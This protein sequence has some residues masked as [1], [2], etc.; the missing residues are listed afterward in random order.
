M[1]WADCRDGALGRL[2][3]ACFAWRCEGHYRK[4]KTG[5]PHRPGQT[6]QHAPLL[7][8]SSHSDRDRD[9]IAPWV[10][11]EGP[12]AMLSRS[13]ALAVA[14]QMGRAL[15]ESRDGRA[16]GGSFALALSRSRHCSA[17]GLCAVRVEC[18]KAV[19][20]LGGYDRGYWLLIWLAGFPDNIS[21]ALRRDTTDYRI[22]GQRWS[23]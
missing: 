3:L 7:P 2:L 12:G 11:G 20:W 16:G 17:D 4:C 5:S 13:P 15:D 8:T 14:V 1:A 21:L 10:V 22:L 19:R 6:L 9:S 23:C 18:R